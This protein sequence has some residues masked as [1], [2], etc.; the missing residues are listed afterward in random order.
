MNTVLVTGGAGYIGSH[1]LVELHNAGYNFVVVDNLSNSSIDTLKRVEE[2]IGKEITFYKVDI[3]DAEGLAKVLESHKV[4]ACIHFAGLKSLGES[5]EMPLEYYQN[6]MGGTFTLVEQLRK[7]GCKNLIFSS[8]ASVYGIPKEIPTSEECPK[9]ECGNPYAKTK[10]MLEDFLSDIQK[11]DPQWNVVLLRYFNPIGAHESGLIGE[12]PAGIPNNLMPYVVRVAAGKYPVLSIYGDDYPTHDGTGVRDFIHV[13]DLARGHIA[14]LSAI[15]A[16]CGLKVYN[17]GTGKGYSVLDVVKAFEKST[18]VK[19]PCQIAPRRPADV[20][21]SYC[22][23]QK[24]KEEMGWSAQYDLEQMCRD[25]W[26]FIV[27]SYRITETV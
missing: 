25:S 4:D 17:L 8:S 19:V 10:S 13:V 3:Q 18:G 11:S 16:D 9:G 21:M 15:K 7:H 6:N 2:I 14:A 24:A 5:L 26:N 23:P 20:A 12:N 22:N 27:K 1:T